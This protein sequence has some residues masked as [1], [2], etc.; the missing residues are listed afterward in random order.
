MAPRPPSDRPAAAAAQRRALGD[1]AKA[2]RRSAI[3]ASAK[4][5]FAANGF[6]HT[7]IGD[8]AKAAGISYGSVYWYFESKEAL[9]HALMD[10]QEQALRDHIERAVAEAP[11]GPAGLAGGEAMFRLA[12][13]A[14]FEF[15]EAD[16]DVAKLLFRDSLAL[17]DRFDR[18]LAG[19]YE[20]FVADIEKAIAA[21]QSAGY[22][23]DKPPR[24][25]AFSVAALI[26][27]LALRRIAT[28]DG[29]SAGV[30]ADFVVTLLL[31]GLRPREEEL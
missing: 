27:Q 15:F 7:T 21:A 31:D 1:D 28:D 5:A 26:G 8:V 6:H 10:D 24:M 2:Q 12:V 29:V 22:V 20:G 17:S 25:L 18:H 19:I 23:V 13:R 16:R 9:F 14:T 3:L 11:H 30:V 4:Q